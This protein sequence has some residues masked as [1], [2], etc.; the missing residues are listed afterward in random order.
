MADTDD[1]ID[2]ILNEDIGEK[3]EYNKTDYD[4]NT[5]LNENNDDTLG[6]NDDELN[7]D[8]KEPEKDIIKD[9]VNTSSE[10]PKKEASIEPSGDTSKEAS[11]GTHTEQ[12]KKEEEKEHRHGRRDV[13]AVG[14]DRFHHH[15][16]FDLWCLDVGAYDVLEDTCDESPSE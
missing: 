16:C 3:I 6:I 13:Q 8:S 14:L 5:I 7:E 11:E 2:N 12:L 15:D 4:I 9:A 1:I 10:E